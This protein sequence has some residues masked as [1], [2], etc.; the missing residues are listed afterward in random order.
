MHR[1]SALFVSFA[2]LAGS[3]AAQCLD[4][5][6]SGTS[7]GSGDNTLFA[8][9]A[10]GFAFPMTGAAGGP[11][12][13]CAVS[14][15]GVLYLTTGGAAIGATANDFGGITQLTGVAGD[16]PRIAPFWKNLVCTAPSSF[17]AVDTSVAGRCAVTWVG[18]NEWL[19]APTKSFRAE[20]FA[21]GAVVFSYSAGMVVDSV[22]ATV[23]VSIGNG[24]VDPGTVDL[25]STAASAT[26]LAYQL[27]DT[28]AVPFDLGGRTIQF[29]PAGSGYA[30][31]TTCAPAFHAAYGNGCYAVGSESFY[32]YFPTAAAAATALNGQSMRLSPTANGYTVTW[33]G[34][35]YVPPSGSAVSLP[36]N[37]DDQTLVIPQAPLPIPGGTASSLWVH[38]N[39]FVSTA[40]SNDAVLD[41][42]TWN[43]PTSSDWSPSANFRN[44]PATAFWCWHDY[45]TASGT[46]RIK[47]HHAVVGADTILYVTWDAVES[48]PAATANPSTFQFQFNLTTGVV[49]YVW[50]SLTAIGTGGSTSLPESHLIG[51]SPGGSSIDGGSITL[52]TALPLTTRPDQLP[53]QLSASPAPVYTLGG[54]SVPITYTVANVPSFAPPLPLG[55]TV[56]IFSVGALPG[57]LDLG[58]VGMPSCSL[59]IAS[60]DVMLATA[61]STSPT[62]SLTLSVPQPLSP[63][64]SF[65]V[66]ALSLF[67]PGSLANGQNPFG[68][69]LSNGVQSW[70]NTF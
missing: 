34:G 46:G 44:A 33:G 52:S 45:N 1:S 53:L 7:L 59:N 17:V 65:F 62:D 43:P 66:Q 22:T 50:Q 2:L 51:Y 13:H 48:Y 29:T 64:L 18:A 60:L 32:Q 49:T 40:A 4:T 25:S 61:G 21:S 15:N 14:T 19:N 24:V 27:F 10:M 47:H 35:T 16:S 70:F 26:G 3:V 67:P 11:F 68:G 8:P 56:L 37:D 12:T 31:A 20:L 23:G 5:S 54:S 42:A 38:T 39:G 55:L 9:V 30:V 6:S 57:G 41:N 36:A 69:V 63:G 28:L 58:F